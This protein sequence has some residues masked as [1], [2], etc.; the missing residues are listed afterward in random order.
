MSASP[1]VSSQAN[2]ASNS[3]NNTCRII[4]S[5]R[6]ILPY[7]CNPSAGSRIN[8]FPNLENIFLG[9]RYLQA[10]TSFEWSFGI[11]L[12][13]PCRAEKQTV[14]GSIILKEAVANELTGSKAAACFLSHC[15]LKTGQQETKNSR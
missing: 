10:R 4:D 1:A 15:D 11:N 9:I 5:I 8:N 13:R 3:W 14:S 12:G 6:N 2:P 7:R